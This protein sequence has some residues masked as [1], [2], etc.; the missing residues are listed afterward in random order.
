MQLRTFLAK[1][2][3]AALADVRTQMGPDAVII[4]SEKAKGG[5]VMVRA[6]IDR[7]D[8]PVF[9]EDREGEAE[10]V[11]D[12]DADFH[13]TLI[14]RLREKP[15]ERQGRK[16]FDRGEL[17][18]SFARHRLPDALAHMLAEESAKTDLSDMTLAL[19]R[20]LDLRMKSAPIDF[21]AAKAFL[22][23]GPNGAGKTAVAAKLA[24]HAKLAGRTALLI[25]GDVAGAGAVARLKEFAEHLDARV[26]TADS[27]FV[28]ANLVGDA[29]EDR[30]LA[31][32]DTAGFD[33][34]QPK[35]AAVF[36]ALA[37]IEL[38]DTLGVVSALADA[39]ETA[40][41]AAALANIGAKRLIVT[42]CDL[43]RRAGALAAAALTPGA[44]LAHITRSPF[45]AGGLETLTPLSLSRLL[46]ASEQESAQ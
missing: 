41:I 31:I 7:P 20:A 1:D 10:P 17:L 8:A 43:A 40:E 44:S 15:A 18:S 42:A 22:L 3:K 27:A 36:A 37:K 39:E 35:L 12:I 13:N 9:G 45:V 24:A 25:A 14:R 34:R 19:A 23:I 2:M 46:A 4:A 26:E 29:V 6:A 38:V 16:R 11:A 32:I 21:T 33:P 30:V 5:G 28:L